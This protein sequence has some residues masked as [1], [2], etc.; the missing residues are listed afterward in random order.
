MPVPGNPLQVSPRPTTSTESARRR[1][2]GGAV[3]AMV[4]SVLAHRR[5][6]GQRTV[7]P[8]PSPPITEHLPNGPRGAGNPASALNFSPVV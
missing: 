8:G 5:R 3:S 2:G 1:A 6:A 4:E 7:C